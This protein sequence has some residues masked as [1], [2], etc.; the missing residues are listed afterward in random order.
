MSHEQINPYVSVDCVVL[1]FDGRQLNV[2]L[3]RQREEGTDENSTGYYKLP[4]SLIYMHETLDEAA[5][6]VLR[7]LTG[8]SQVNLYQF[9]AFGALNRLDNQRDRVWLEHFHR[10]EKS[11]ERIVSVGYFSLIRINRTM[12][13]LDKGYE[14]CWMPLSD[15]PQLAFDHNDIISKAMEKIA[16]VVEAMPEIVFSLLPRKFTASQLFYAYSATTGKT[17]DIRN[18]HKKLHTMPFVVPLEE[19][20]K[21]VNHR[22]AR[23]Y[24][25][26]RRLLVP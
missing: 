4:G 22:A 21:D 11:L 2:L 5:Q 3:V 18:F 23:L 19:K 25:F 26:D 16:G 17:M 13:Q 12:L 8:L 20:Q 9:Y 1:G 10:L 24:R 14:A 15:L 7:Q 6:R